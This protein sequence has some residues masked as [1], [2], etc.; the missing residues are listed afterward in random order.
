MTTVQVVLF[1]LFMADAAMVH[2]RYGGN[3]FP[4]A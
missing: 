3:A 2:S 1:F 4:L